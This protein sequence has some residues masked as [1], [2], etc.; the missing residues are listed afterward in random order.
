MND[1]PP[2]FTDQ[3]GRETLQIISKADRFNRWMYNQ[4]HS[5]LK[6]EVLEIGSGIGNISQFV[7]DAGFNITLSD[8]NPEYVDLLKKKF[9]LKE[10]VR[11][12]LSINLLHTEFENCYRKLEEKF[13]CIFLLN[14]IE[15]LQN[16]SAAIKNCRFL[17][18]PGGDLIILAPAYQWLYCK[19]DKE[20]GHYRRYTLKS[21]SLQFQNN[22]IQIVNKKY[23]NFLGIAG[24]FVFGKIF[25]KK[26]LGSNEMSAFNKLVPFAT[27][28]DKLFLH[29]AGLSVIMIG[30]KK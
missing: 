3:A 26:I 17:L 9:E 21:L 16:D 29:K 1:N 25:G 19:F 30:V 11:D 13:D 24:W 27:M 6:G 10:N 12:I 15:H 18:K 14:V 23:F 8:Y 7:V 20:L 2:R 4:F 28:L 5:F 22:G